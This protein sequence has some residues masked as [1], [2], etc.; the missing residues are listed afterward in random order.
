MT[1]SYDE[2]HELAQRLENREI[3]AQRRGGQHSTM[4]KV[5]TV[6]LYCEACDDKCRANAADTIRTFGAMHIGCKVE[7]L[8]IGSAR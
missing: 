6:D 1:Y 7:A 8:I 5:N 4:D 2:L 3:G